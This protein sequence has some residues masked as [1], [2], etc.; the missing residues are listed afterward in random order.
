MHYVLPFTVSVKFLLIVISLSKLANQSYNPNP[1]DSGYAMPLQ[2][3]VDPDQLTS[4]LELHCLSL[5][6]MYSILYQQPVSST[7]NLIG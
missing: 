3:S 5:S 4:D 6:T 1:T 2:N 7:C